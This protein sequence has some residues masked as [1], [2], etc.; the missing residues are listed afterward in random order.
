MIFVNNGEAVKDVLV[1]VALYNESGDM[2]EVKYVKADI[3]NGI[4]S[5]ESPIKNYLG[6]YRVKILGWRSLDTMESVLT[7]SD[8]EL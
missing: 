3:S 5:I 8:Y 7:Y 4:T 2:L 6:A 1:L